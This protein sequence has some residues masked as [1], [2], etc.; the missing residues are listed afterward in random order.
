MAM[1]YY[2]PVILTGTDDAAVSLDGKVLQIMNY[3]G[4]SSASCYTAGI[5]IQI[6]SPVQRIRKLSKIFEMIFFRQQ[7]M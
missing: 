5:G 6:Y 1:D 7:A 2:A 3:F 4:C